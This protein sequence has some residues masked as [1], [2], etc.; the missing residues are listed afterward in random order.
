MPA[1]HPWPR[2]RRRSAQGPT[3]PHID[4]T[5]ML[6]PATLSVSHG[7]AALV[8]F[9]APFTL[10]PNIRRHSSS[11]VSARPLSDCIRPA[12]DATMSSW[13]HSAP[14]A[15]TASSTCCRSETSAFSAM[16]L[17][18]DEWMLSAVSRATPSVQIKHRHPG[19]A[20]GQ[21]QAVRSWTGRRS[22][23]KA[24]EPLH[25][26]PHGG[27]AKARLARRDL[28]W[29]LHTPFIGKIQ[30]NRESHPRRVF[31]VHGAKHL[32]LRSR[33]RKFNRA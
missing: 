32:P 13:P 10:T 6:R 4:D 17:P 15:A 21:F 27:R 29:R 8:T 16:A 2:R 26:A 18:E 33:M 20:P 31:A 22:A 3:W 14:T 9:S 7:R 12:L 19:A 23:R 5:M 24:Y 11:S 28:S 1:E 30:L 25:Q